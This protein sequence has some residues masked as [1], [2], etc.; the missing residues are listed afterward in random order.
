M[1]APSLGAAPLTVAALLVAGSALLS[2]L[3]QLGIARS[4]GVAAVRMVAQLLLVGVVLRTVFAWRSAWLVAAVV[5]VMFATAGH[6]VLSRQEHRF[7]GWWRHGLG[8]G[9]MFVATLIVATPA[10]LAMHASPWFDPRVTIP[11]IGIVLGSV[12]NGVSIS[13][14]TFTEALVREHAAIEAQLAL[15]AT[16]PAALGR[17]QRS[18]LRNGLIPIVNQMSAAG[19]ITLPG[20]MTGQ[21]LAG[22]PPLEAAT[23]QIFILGLL[24]GAT[25]LGS[26]ATIAFAAHRATDER[27]RLRLD[28]IDTTGSS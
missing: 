26:V 11:L 5:A 1:T 22:M 6:E 28:R 8:A 18:A 13:L 17:V 16:R 15:G 14:S 25:T 21:I 2:L 24:A 9:T 27:D 19:I 4:L 7:T 20:M 3:F 10:L 12:L 23:Y